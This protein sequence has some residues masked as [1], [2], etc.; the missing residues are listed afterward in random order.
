MISFIS[1]VDTLGALLSAE[2]TETARVDESH[3]PQTPVSQSSHIDLSAWRPPSIAFCGNAGSRPSTIRQ[4]EN[5]PEPGHFG[6]Q[7]QGLS[8]TLRVPAS[9]LDALLRQAEELIPAKAT[10][11]Q[12]VTELREIS[13]ALDF[14]GNRMA[15]DPAARACLARRL[16]EH[17]S[18]GRSHS[19]NGR[20]VYQ[21]RL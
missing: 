3:P 14:V 17:R 1:M 10:A 13:Q 15:E 5:T 8:E 11:A 6:D 2:S 18:N 21:S 4:P 7:K 16:V 9:K 12:R 20:R 19:S